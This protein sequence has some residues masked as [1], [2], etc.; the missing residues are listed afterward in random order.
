[1]NKLFGWD[2][3]PGVTSN[4][5]EDTCSGYNSQCEEC[6]LF[7]DELGKCPYTDNEEWCHKISL[8]TECENCKKKM[9]K[10]Q[11]AFKKEEIADFDS[12][13]QFFCC[14]VKC[15]KEI[16]KDGE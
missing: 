16:L 5:I 8:I 12:Y 13:M 7:D 4:M 3:P 9:N 11:G 1:M 10:V 6:D 14:S 15:A 2:L